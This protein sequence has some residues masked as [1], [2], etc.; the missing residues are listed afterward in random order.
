MRLV[1]EIRF[2]DA[3]LYA[4]WAGCPV[5]SGSWTV[6]AAVVGS[7]AWSSSPSR[8]PLP[9]GART[10]RR[11]GRRRDNGHGQWVWRG[12]WGVQWL[13]SRS[14]GRR[15]LRARR[16]FCVFVTHS[17]VP[18]QHQGNRGFPRSF[19]LRY[20]L[21]GRCHVVH[22]LGSAREEAEVACDDAADEVVALAI[23]VSY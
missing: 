22:L 8:V 13:A 20:R 9:M 2:S 19:E 14:S 3:T 18:T 6:T 4:R 10:R 7:L 11:R 21:V 5:N 15:C 12:N 23:H 17:P 16:D 1:S